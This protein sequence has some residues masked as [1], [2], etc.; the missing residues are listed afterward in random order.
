MFIDESDAETSEDLFD[1]EDDN[2]DREVDNVGDVI[3]SG[4][5]SEKYG[6]ARAWLA[7]MLLGFNVSIFCKNSHIS[8]DLHIVSQFLLPNPCVNCQNIYSG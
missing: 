3:G 6:W 4:P 7:V 2:S 5:Y 1:L 8:A